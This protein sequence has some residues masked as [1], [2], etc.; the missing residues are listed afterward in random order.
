MCA[1]K[2]GSPST[3]ATS[4]LYLNLE[5]KAGRAIDY[6]NVEPGDELFVS[7]LARFRP[8]RHLELQLQQTRH[9][10]DRESGRLFRADLTE[11][12]ATWQFDLRTFVRW[13]GQRIAVD[14]NPALYVDEVEA[15]SRELANQLLFAY[16]INP[17]TVIFAGYSDSLRDDPAGDLVRAAR[18]LFLKLGYAWRG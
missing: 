8:G 7:T 2:G 16:K 12:R 18:T 9:V 5:T 17:Q 15:A 14:R 3:T 1:P 10:L 13:I 6:A 4:W 11:I